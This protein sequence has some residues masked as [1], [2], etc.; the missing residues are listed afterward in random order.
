LSADDQSSHGLTLSTYGTY[1]LGRGFILIGYASRQKETFQGIDSSSTRTGGTLTYSYSRPLFGMIYFS[2]GM[3]NNA[4]ND[5]GGSLGYVG[6]V[7]LRRQLAG[8][9]VDTDFSYAQNVQTIL[10]SYTTSNYSYG[11]MARRKFGSNSSWNVSYRGIRSGLTQLPGYSNRS[12]TFM[13]I[14]NR[15]RYGLSGSYSKSHGTAL[16]SSTGVLTPD[17]L[18]PLISPDRAIY[19][20]TVYGVGGSVIP[21]KRMVIN[22]NWYR[23]NSETTTVDVFS[24]NNSERYYG[25]M[26]YTLRK[27]M[28]RAGYWRVYQGIGFNGLPPSTRNTYYFSI[29][30]WFNVF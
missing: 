3:V 24:N 5:T 11:G 17:P 28:F 29:S 23:A 10:N 27:L 26:Q 2:F 9:Q 6:S 7:A 20:G 25:Q 15:G 21:I 19:G 14:L 22:I 18:A 8:W 4:S 30:R 1:S 16:L 13:T 12:D